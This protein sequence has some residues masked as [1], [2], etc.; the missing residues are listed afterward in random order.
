[1]YITDHFRSR[2]I[3]RNLFPKWLSTGMINRFVMQKLSQTQK[4]QISKLTGMLIN[5]CPGMTIVT[6]LDQKTAITIWKNR[7]GMVS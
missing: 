7:V 5:V 2:G 4:Q 6:T 3:K 1:M